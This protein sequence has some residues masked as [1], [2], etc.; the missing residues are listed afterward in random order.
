MVPNEEIVTD[1][2][3]SM[4]KYN[5]SDITSDDSN[6]NDCCREGDE[7]EITSFHTDDCF[8]KSSE[9]RKKE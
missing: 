2:E 4:S 6:H 1:R 9:N 8:H 7:N 3:R 5:V